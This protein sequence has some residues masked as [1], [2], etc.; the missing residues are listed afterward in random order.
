LQAAARA[1]ITDRRGTL[2]EQLNRRGFGSK[3]TPLLTPTQTTKSN[4]PLASATPQPDVVLGNGLGGFTPDGR[5]YVIRT[6]REHMTPAPWVNVLANADF[7]TV[8]SESGIG[9]SWHENAHEFRLT[10][11][12]DDSVGATGGE[13]IYL[14]D[15]ESGYFWSPAPFPSPGATPYICRHGFGYSVF[16]HTE[17]G[18]HSELWIYVDLVES[19]KYSVLKLRNKSGRTR[20]LSATGYV[21]WVLGDLRPKTAMHVVTELDASSGGLFARNAYNTEFEGRIA[22]FDVEDPTRTL[23]GDRTEFLGR[24]GTPAKPDAMTRERLSGNFGAGLDPCGAAQ[25]E[26]SL[27]DG[28]EREIIFRLG[29][30]RDIDA[31]RELGKRLRKAGS[32]RA[33]LRQ[34][35]QY[36][37]HALS[38]VRVETPDDALNVMANGWL[39]YQ[40]LACRVWARTGFY[41]SGGAFGFRDQLQD[42]MALIH[43]EPALVREHLLRCAARQFPEGDVQHWW[44]PPAGR[45]VRTRCSDDYLWLPLA[46]HRYVSCTGDTGVLDESAH[47]LDGRALTDD[48][49]SYYDLPAPSPE[50]ASLYE[51]CKR[52]VVNGLRFGEHGL[53]LM[54]SGDWNDGMNLVGIHGRGESVWLGFFLYQVLTSFAE[55]A[56]LQD[57]AAFAARCREEAARL[58]SNIGRDAWDGAWYRRAWFDDGSPLGSSTNVEC[59]IDSIAQSWSVLSGAGD[60]ERSRQAMESLDHRLIRRDARLVQLLDPPFD[61]SDMDPGY[62]KG[63]VPGVRENGGQYTHAAVWAAMAFAALGDSG[64]AWELL[65]LLNPVNHSSSPRLA[66]IYKTEPYVVAAD[67]YAL[68]P[69]VGRGGWTWYTGSAGWLYRLIVESL[70][71]LQRKA[72]RLRITPCM[73]SDWDRYALEYRYGDTVYRID[74][75][76]TGTAD[77][78]VG[79][80]TILDGIDLGDQDIPLRDDHVAHAVEVRIGVTD[81]A[82]IEQKA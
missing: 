40:S 71:G 51:H 12:S 66:S 29:A 60:P 42:T 56:E 28:H 81:N 10:P 1:I 15:E 53:P 41:Q 57:D 46:A 38:A 17:D 11:W 61:T 30:A 13:A 16:E 62:I 18:I 33:A 39:V 64:R 70:L 31:A 76:R 27:P 36:W 35:R 65:T 78:A 58:R 20:R 59:S 73:P 26:F 37:E 24:N 67:I 68:A 79:I 72:D 75:I 34:V 77:S 19:V 43:A 9:Y 80:S 5:E 3:S 63:Y 32:A 49:E 69:H 54:G 2:A 21:E 4:R 25:V 45:G 7:G 82:P 74:V 52:A 48:E 44:H 23:S 22:F 8:V 14:R 47:F 6:T 55:L 50:V